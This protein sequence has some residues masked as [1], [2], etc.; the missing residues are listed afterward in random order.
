MKYVE[1][2]VLGVY[3]METGVGKWYTIL[4]YK[5]HD[6][7][8]SGEVAGW[9]ACRMTFVAIAEGLRTLKEPCNVTVYTQ[10]NFIS[11]AMQGVWKRKSNLDLYALLDDQ[12]ARHTVKYE[13]YKNIKPVFRAKWKEIRAA[14]R[15]ANRVE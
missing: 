1:I 10:Y 5:G 15:M 9:N 4:R 8:I 7:L 6:K 12:G 14:E 2:Y 13:F 11:N 3:I